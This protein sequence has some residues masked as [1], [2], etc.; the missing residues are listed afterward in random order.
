MAEKSAASWPSSIL[1]RHSERDG[2]YIR[3]L[4]LAT[5]FISCLLFVGCASD[6]APMPTPDGASSIGFTTGDGVELKG[7]LFGEG[8][9]GVVLAH[10][11]ASDQTGWWEFGQVL[12][13]EGY[14]ALSFDFRGYGESGGSKDINLIDVDIRAALEV[15]RDRGASSI[16]L[17]GASMG[18]TASLKVAASGSVAGVVSLSSPLDFRGLT[19]EKERV[20]VPVLLMVS[21]EDEP[22]MRN[23]EAAFED[24]IVVKET[25]ESVVYQDANEHGTGILN[26]KYGDAARMRILGFLAANKP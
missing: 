3:P 19:V 15:L 24:G 21:E 7:K 11:F 20:R 16:F 6:R 12:A 22:G 23:L 5:A 26:G 13:D 10:M 18:G 4:V 14:I 1:I 17:I 25:S 2:K 8:D 9:T